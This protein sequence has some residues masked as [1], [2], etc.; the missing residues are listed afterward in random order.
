M[1]SKRLKQVSGLLKSEISTI[2]QTRLKDPLV[3]FTTVTDVVVSNDLRIAKV[4][5]SVYGDDQQKQD[6]LRGLERA[7]AYIQSELSSRVR[8][9]YM[10]VLHFY[11]DESLAYGM[12][13]NRLLDKIQNEETEPTPE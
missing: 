5:I 8:L 9:R 7:R 12:H 11:L 4:Y 2:M 6:T 13:I 3:G 10:P 1:P